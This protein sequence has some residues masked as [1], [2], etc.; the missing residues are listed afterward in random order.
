MVSSSYMNNAHTARKTQE[1]LQKFEWEVWSHPSPY[2]PDLAPNLGSKR[3][4]GSGFFSNSDV[5]TSAENWLNE[6]GRDF[7]ES[8]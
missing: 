2:S 5:K 6:Q 7:Y 8:S 4:S 1:L 3:L